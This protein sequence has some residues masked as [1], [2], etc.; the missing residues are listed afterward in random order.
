MLNQDSFPTIFDEEIIDI[1]DAK[2]QDLAAFAKNESIKQGEGPEGCVTANALRS[3]YLDD[4]ADKYVV[5]FDSLALGEFGYSKMIEMLG[6]LI[7]NKETSL[8][9]VLNASKAFQIAMV[10]KYGGNYHSYVELSSEQF[11]RNFLQDFVIFTSR[12]IAQQIANIQ[13]YLNTPRKPGWIN[14][15]FFAA[16]IPTPYKYEGPLSDKDIANVQAVFN[17]LFLTAFAN[18]SRPEAVRLLSDVKDLRNK[19]KYVSLTYSKCDPARMEQ[20][21]AP[22]KERKFEGKRSATLMTYLISAKNEEDQS[23]LC[24]IADGFLV[25]LLGIDGLLTKRTEK[26]LR[27]VVRA[28]VTSPCYLNRVT[29]QVSQNPYVLYQASTVSMNIMFDYA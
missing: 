11:E 8:L 27:A 7:V 15:G 28:L 5:L 17:N 22:I 2:V 16:I 10:G 24:E 21:L 25:G 1:L 20:D 23:C 13:A 3:A 6:G 19:G 4:F 18:E 26:N 14:P 29:I 12:E 9:S